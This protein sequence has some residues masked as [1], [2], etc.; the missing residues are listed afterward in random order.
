MDHEL[1]PRKR[2]DVLKGTGALGAAGLIGLAGCADTSGGGDGSGGDSGDSGGDGGSGDG[3]GDGTETEDVPEDA[4]VMVVGTAAS[5]TANFAAMQGFGTAVNENSDEV[6]MDVRP[7]EGMAANIGAMNRDEIDLGLQTDYNAAKIREGEGAYE[8]LDFE[9]SQ[10]VQTATTEWLL[11]SNDES[12]QSYEDIDSDV[13]VAPGPPGSSVLEYFADIFGALDIEYNETPVGFGDIG[14][15]LAE[16][17]IDVGLAATNNAPTASQQDGAELIEPGWVQ[18]IK[19]TVDAQ[20]LGLSE[21]N[22]SAL[23]DTPG[24]NPF[25]IETDLVPDGYAYVPDQV[26]AMVQTTYLCG[27]TDASYDAIY[28]MLET[29]WDLRDSMG[30][31]HNFLSY[32]QY[33]DHWTNRAYEDVPFHDA[34]AD[35]YEEV[36]LWEDDFER[37]D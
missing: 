14:S 2:R 4:E 16:G 10:I 22:F 26:P 19:G 25:Y 17:R 34:A 29:A 3:S 35:F 23:Q 8:D 1:S 18:Q 20:L 36:G 7:S 13:R 9:L 33:E 24:L 11:I 21:E 28:E 27:P 31:Y 5:P 6:Y 30:D 12:I 37:A 32:H 15:A